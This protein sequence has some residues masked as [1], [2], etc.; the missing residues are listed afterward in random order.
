L[1]IVAY[2]LLE[3]DYENFFNDIDGSRI[4]RIPIEYDENFITV[5]YLPR[6]KC[7]AN[8]LRKGIYPR[9]DMIA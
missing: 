4:E 1:F 5:E 6:L 3:S 8:C 7:L 9:K 2:G